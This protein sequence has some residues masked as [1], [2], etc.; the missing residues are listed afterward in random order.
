MF[1]YKNLSDY[2]FEKL[3]CDIMSKKLGV[4]LRTFAKGKDG[5][6]DATDDVSTHNIIVQAKHYI[7]S[8][9][10][11]LY[12]TL[13][14]EVN[15]VDDL[16]PNQY[17]VCCAQ[18]LTPGNIDDIYNLFSDYM[19]AVSYTHLRAHETDSYLVC[20]LLLEKKKT[21]ETLEHTKE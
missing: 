18:E 20:R 21:K 7:N 16:K 11:A 4:Q 3:C 13:K 9:Y 5:G 10:S 6:I 14:S 12:N 8:S 2:E 17:Y 19:K 1:N 15:K